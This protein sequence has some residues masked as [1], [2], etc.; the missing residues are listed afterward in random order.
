MPQ[1]SPVD[2]KKIRVPRLDVDIE[3]AT[4]D[5]MDKSVNTSAKADRLE[6]E[7][8]KLAQEQIDLAIGKVASNS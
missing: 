8:T 7:A 2:I 6:N 3:S 5:L 1:L 4:A